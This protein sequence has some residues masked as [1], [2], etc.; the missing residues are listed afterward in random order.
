MGKGITWLGDAVV[1]L[2]KGF[3]VPICKRCGLKI[4]KKLGIKK[5]KGEHNA[6]QRKDGVGERNL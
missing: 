1:V 3:F 5:S 4:D 6:R 2:H